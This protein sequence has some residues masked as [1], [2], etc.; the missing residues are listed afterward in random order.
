MRDRERGNLVSSGDECRP[1]EPEQECC[2][3]EA[4]CCD[5]RANRPISLENDTIAKY[6][7]K[8]RQI[9]IEQMDFGYIV[10]VGCQ[11]FA[12][13][14]YGKVINNLIDYLK[15]PEATEANW[16]KTRTLSN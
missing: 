5:D 3:S 12:I 2:G 7:S 13:E 10:R 15:D 6:P 4:R 8:A 16:Y 11:T 9:T 14:S 1:C